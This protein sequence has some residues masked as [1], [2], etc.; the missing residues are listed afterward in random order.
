[1]PPSNLTKLWKI[2]NIIFV[3]YEILKE[4]DVEIVLRCLKLSK[5]KKDVSQ[6]RF[7]RLKGTVR[8]K[9]NT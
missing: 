4:I 1:M 7:N 9:L 2:R 6:V 5:T 8:E 3:N